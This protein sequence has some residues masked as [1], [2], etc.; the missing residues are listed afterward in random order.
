MVALKYYRFTVEI[1]DI[2]C[3][4][5]DPA[6]SPVE[7]SGCMIEPE[8]IEKIVALSSSP[9]VLPGFQSFG[10]EP[11]LLG[12]EIVVVVAGAVGVPGGVGQQNPVLHVRPLDL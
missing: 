3:N 1:G 2:S 11:A 5:L 12:V 9:G 7:L 8:K 10:D 6:G 4:E